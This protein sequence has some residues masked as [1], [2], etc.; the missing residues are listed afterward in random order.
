MRAAARPRRELKARDDEVTAGRGSAIALATERLRRRYAVVRDTVC[1]SSWTVTTDSLWL[2]QR[3]SVVTVQ[4][5]L[6]T[7]TCVRCAER[8]TPPRFG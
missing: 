3:E 1:R 2:C 5:D 6:H 7:V 4:D 8:S